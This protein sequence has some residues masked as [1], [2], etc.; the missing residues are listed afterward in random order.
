MTKNILA[1]IVAVIIIAGAFYITGFE[2]ENENEKGEDQNEENSGN[3]NEQGGEQIEVSEEFIA[4][5]KDAGV[6]VYG[7]E[8]C[9]AC[10]AL[11]ESLGGYEM[12]EPIYVECT[13]EEERCDEEMEGGLV[14]E[15]QIEGKLFKTGVIPV[16][17]LA[18]ETGCEL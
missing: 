13:V 14:P 3:G 17:L 2:G 11:V 5:L 18:D 4:C 10:S 12:A 6:V 16:Q 1:I 9:P 7:S 8:W 15:I